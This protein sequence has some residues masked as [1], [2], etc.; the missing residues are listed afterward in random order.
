MLIEVFQ[1]RLYLLTN[2]IF[3]VLLIGLAVTVFA[4]KIKIISIAC[5][6]KS[7]NVCLFC[8]NGLVGS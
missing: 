8:V 5:V 4:K 2:S 1:E 3:Y 7:R 6:A